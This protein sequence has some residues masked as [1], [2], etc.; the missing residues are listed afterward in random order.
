MSLRAAG[1]V[2]AIKYQADADVERG[3]QTKRKIVVKTKMETDGEIKSE[4]ETMMAV[5]TEAK[6]IVK[7]KTETDGKIKN[8]V[9]STT[10]TEI[11]TGSDV[12]AET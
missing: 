9:E 4:I 5:K 6:I 2:S 11:E 7:T 3:I 12:E 10:D 1:F 8:V